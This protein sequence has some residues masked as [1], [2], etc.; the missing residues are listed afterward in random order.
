MPAIL[1]KDRF[2]ARVRPKRSA[3]NLRNA[4]KLNC[5]I[6]DPRFAR[7]FEAEMFPGSQAA[8]ATF[9]AGDEPGEPAVTHI[10]S[11]GRYCGPIGTAAIAFLLAELD[12]PLNTFIL[13]GTR[14]RPDKELG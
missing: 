6:R 7:A 10:K 4:N 13:L 11:G 3:Q 12:P 14:R 8:H 2:V 5:G 1:T 9:G